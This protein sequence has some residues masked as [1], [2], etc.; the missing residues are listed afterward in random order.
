MKVID[1]VVLILE[2]DKLEFYCLQF[3][4]QQNSVTTM[5]TW[6][7]TTVIDH[8]TRRGNP[9]YSAAMDMSK[10]FDL[11]K[12]SKLFDTLMK[13]KVDPIFLRLLLYIYTHQKCSVRWCRA[14]SDWFSVKSGVRQGGGSSGIF[15][16]VYIEE[17]QSVL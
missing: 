1:L 2:G 11:V 17:L 6:T 5:C 10:A 9:I 16:A 12:W 3:A 4:Y 8:F 15:F 14:N 13:Q 7:A